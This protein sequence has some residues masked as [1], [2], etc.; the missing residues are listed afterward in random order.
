MEKYRIVSLGDCDLKKQTYFIQKKGFW[1]WRMIHIKENNES[2]RLSFNSF[3]EAEF[4]IL[5][6]YCRHN[7]EIY[8]PYPNEFHYEATSYFY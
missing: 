3:V 4:H 5:K 7:G 6:N 2:K 1:G 8:Q